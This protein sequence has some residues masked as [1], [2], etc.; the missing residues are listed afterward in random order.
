M[1]V[2]T[3]KSIRSQDEPQGYPWLEERL[4]EMRTAMSKS[5]KRFPRGMVLKKKEFMISV[6]LSCRP[7]D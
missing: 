7:R 3:E 5:G 4:K 1:N 6:D 2:A